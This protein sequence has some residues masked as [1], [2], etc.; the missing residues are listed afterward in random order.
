MYFALTSFT[1]P[2]DR[3]TIL[4]H[5]TTVGFQKIVWAAKVPLEEAGITNKNP[6][7][8]ESID[9]HRILGQSLI[10]AS[11]C[12]RQGSDKDSLRVRHYRGSIAGAFFFDGTPDHSSPGRSYWPGELTISGLGWQIFENSSITG[13]EA[14]TELYHLRARQAIIVPGGIGNFERVRHPRETSPSRH[15]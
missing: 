15:I 3:K 6:S 4:V 12:I 8:P 5:P 14:S 9:R 7:I 11:V 1:G 13:F 2:F 10:D